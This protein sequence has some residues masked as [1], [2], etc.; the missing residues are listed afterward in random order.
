MLGRKKNVGV[1]RISE[2]ALKC[3]I[4]RRVDRFVVEVEVNTT[5]SKAYVNNIS[6]FERSSYPWKVRLLYKDRIQDLDL[7]SLR[8]CLQ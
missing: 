8:E 2:L 1:M 7:K 3:K 4:L 5:A 6:R